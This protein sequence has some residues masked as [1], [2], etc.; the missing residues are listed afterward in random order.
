MKVWVNQVKAV[1]WVAN[2][3][4]SLGLQEDSGGVSST[5]PNT[6]SGGTMHLYITEAQLA[7]IICSMGKK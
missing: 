4:P 1:Q 5:Q 6:T 2:M 3:F 7:A